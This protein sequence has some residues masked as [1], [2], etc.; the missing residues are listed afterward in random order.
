[1][2]YYFTQHKPSRLLFVSTGIVLSFAFG[3]LLTWAVLNQNVNQPKQ[4]PSTTTER[5]ESGFS[6][7][8]PLLECEITENQGNNSL[9]NLKGAVT[10]IINQKSDQKISIY[11]RDLLNGPWYGYNEGE[12]FAP[13]SLLKLP[14]VIAYLKYLEDKP[15][16]METEITYDNL[17]ESNIPEH[18]NLQVGK[19]YSIAELVE[20][21]ITLSDNVAFQLLVA[22]LPPNYLQKVHRD[23]DITYP[24]ETTPADFVSVRS[25]SSIFRILYNSS[26]LS[27]ENSQY[28]LELL[29]KTQFKDG[30]VAGLPKGIQVSHKFGVKNAEKQEH[31]FQLHDC[32]IVYAPDQPYLACIMTKG[33]NTDELKSTISEISK[34]IYQSVV[35]NQN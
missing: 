6:Y 31:D 34:T 3:C 17:L 23:L 28:L 33:N 14:V 29:S 8:N 32:G 18:L 12:A 13:Q 21:S 15:G 2:H 1:M 26:Y 20:R 4:P 5:R 19:K 22:N 10:E 25:Y 35:T 27:R 7:I 9:R 24:S 16:L 11:Y 30:L